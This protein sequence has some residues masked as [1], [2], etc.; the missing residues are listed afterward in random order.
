MAERTVNRSRLRYCMFAV[1]TTRDVR[2]DVR[3]A[4]LNCLIEAV[5]DDVRWRGCCRDLDAGA[6]IR[7]RPWGADHSLEE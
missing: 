6:A 2:Q 7:V 1:A 4:L 3:D 5:E